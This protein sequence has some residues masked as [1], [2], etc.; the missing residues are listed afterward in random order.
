MR[1][2]ATYG[3]LGIYVYDI[4]YEAFGNEC[5][6]SHHEVLYLKLSTSQRAFQ[7]GS[8]VDAVILCAGQENL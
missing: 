3:Y 6:V 7:V 8:P 4:V 5:R 1:V 2:K